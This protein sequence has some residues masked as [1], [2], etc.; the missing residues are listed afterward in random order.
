MDEFVISPIL[1]I[2]LSIIL[3]YASQCY[4]K[5][6]S[7]ST[8]TH[9]KEPALAIQF[10][11]IDSDQLTEIGQIWSIQEDRKGYLWFSGER[12][13]VRFDG[14]NYKTFRQKHGDQSGL[15]SGYIP[16]ILLTKDGDIWLASH[17]G[18]FQYDP[19][20]ERFDPILLPS[21]ISIIWDLDEDPDDGSLWIGFFGRGIGRYDPRTKEYVE[22][23]FYREDGNVPGPREHSYAV[24][25]DRQGAV[26]AGSDLALHRLDPTTKK[27]TS[28]SRENSNT[29]YLHLAPVTSL[30]DDFRDNLW[31]GTVNGLYRYNYLSQRFTRYESH[32]ND[33]NSLSSGSVGD[34]VLD[35]QG[36]LWVMLD[37][38]G[39]N[40]YHPELDG[41]SHIFAG[42]GSLGS[43]KNNSVRRGFVSQ[44]GDLW[45]GYHPYGVSVSNRFANYF[46]TFVNTPSSPDS[47]SNNT[48]NALAQ[49]PNGDLWLGTE[50]G[51]NKID[52]HSGNVT[53]YMHA[54]GDVN[55]L[56]K[57][58]VL[59]VLADSQG[60]IWAGTWGGGLNLLDP[61]KAQFT[62]YFNDYQ[63]AE[64]LPSDAVFSLL[65]LSPE[66]LLVGA[67]N[68]LA[69]MDVET[70][71]FISIENIGSGV[72]KLIHFNDKYVLV[73][74]YHALQFLD[75]TS[76]NVETNNAFTHFP[77][78]IIN[79]IV[80]ENLTI[81]ATSALGVFQKGRRDNLFSEVY[82]FEGLSKPQYGQIIKGSDDQIWLGGSSGITVL[83]GKTRTPKIFN[84]AYGFPSGSYTA[85]RAAIELQDKRLAF[86]GA[87]GLVILN[88][89]IARQMLNDAKPIFTGLKILDRDVSVND[90]DSP[91]DRPI[92]D[93]QRIVLKFAQNLITIEYSVLDFQIPTEADFA[94][95]LR[96][97]EENW[98][99]VG[100]RRFA[101]YTNLYPGKYTFEV[102]LADHHSNWSGGAAAIDLVVLP[103]WWLTWQAIL[104]YGAGI[105]LILALIS[106][107]IWSRFQRERERRINRK[108][109]DL[110]QIKDEFL[111]RTSHELRTPLNGIIGLTESVIK[112][113]ENRIDMSSRKKLDIVV[114][115]GRR[116][117]NIINDIMDFAKLK[118]HELTLILKPIHL[119]PVV[120]D[121][122][123]LFRSLIDENKITLSNNVPV[124]FSS[125]LADEQRLTQILFNLVG[126]ALK[127]TQLGEISVSAED[128]GSY[129]IISVVDSGCGIRKQDQEKIFMPFE[130]STNYHKSSMVGTGIGLP[131]TRSLVTL[132]GGRIDVYSELGKGSIFRFSLAKTAKPD[133][134]IPREEP[135]IVEFSSARVLRI[136]V[137][138]DDAVNR[139]VIQSILTGNSVVVSECA[140][141]LD[142]IERLGNEEFDLLI[143]DVMLPDM[144]GYQV[145]Y[146]LR[147]RYTESQLPIIMLTGDTSDAVFTKGREA[148]ANL[149]LHKP[150]SARDIIAHVHAFA[151]AKEG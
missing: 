43:L 86:G 36:R 117:N 33:S 81:W 5:S 126:N 22:Y 27:M 138:D 87:N 79:A 31:I 105:C 72:E 116:L 28:Y 78:K 66:K 21:H 14:L 10:R 149:V 115:S 113:T 35:K 121:T 95:R 88:P 147:E 146:Q 55:T 62:H 63:D 8:K 49:A 15:P 42:G 120:E 7:Y 143:L 6:P 3:G 13:V 58:T 50:N 101:T 53:R 12:G 139:M 16:D 102:R 1:A 17:K 52:L 107:T 109:T 67:G 122:F 76:F 26:W 56:S 119:Y 32:A 64:S 71:T 25:K 108:L 11:N 100:G 89:E 124:T 118:N 140:S 45:L 39:I 127:F 97:F 48:I 90:L 132:H 111:V 69:L 85:P 9:S 129:I 61:A 34:I 74:N 40:L 2:C 106:Y 135:A 57:N 73:K 112:E 41:F 82:K 142:A 150:V 70:G 51:L 77:D 4:G 98:R 46:E 44:S 18:L 23:P 125:F 19:A 104:G 103:P 68:G 123:A 133:Q 136:L 92:E 110:D 148:G 59:S 65:E 47:I 54:D 91:L 94:I 60:R 96:G 38:G 144:S 30:C 114:N 131:V 137:V 99:E 20:K 134:A 151:R 141:G 75:K 130:Q 128:D 93:A 83:S 24:I 37:G 80:D 29:G 84:S 145:C